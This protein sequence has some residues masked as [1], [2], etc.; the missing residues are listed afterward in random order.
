[1]KFGFL[2]LLICL[3][4]SIVWALS[5]NKFETIG[6]KIN[7]LFKPFYKNTKEENDNE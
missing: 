7:K 2:F 5:A 3:T 1:M 6:K 4:L